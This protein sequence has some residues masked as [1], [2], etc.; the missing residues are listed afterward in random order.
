MITLIS[1]CFSILSTTIT[2]LV[3]CRQRRNRARAERAL[4]QEFVRSSN[5]SS[6]INIAAV[7]SG[8]VYNTPTHWYYRSVEVCLSKK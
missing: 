1:V 3:W 4:D 7:D 6:P 5:N 8:I 2:A